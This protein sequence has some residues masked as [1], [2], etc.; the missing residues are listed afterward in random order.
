MLPKVSF[1]KTPVEV[2]EIT[3]NN[4]TENPSKEAERSIELERLIG[5]TKQMII[6]SL[7]KSQPPQPKEPEPVPEPNLTPQETVPEPE[8]AHKTPPRVP[9]PVTQAP[10]SDNITQ[11]IPT[12][13]KVKTEPD[14]P[15]QA[16]RIDDVVCLDSDEDSVKQNVIDL[17][18]DEASQASKIIP[19][20]ELFKCPSCLV[21]YKGSAGLKIHILSCF[22]NPKAPMP[23]AFCRV[24][25]NG[26]Q[27][28]IDHYVA[29]HQ[30]PS[31]SPIYACEQCG[32][33]SNCFR[34]IKKHVKYVHK[35]NG[36]TVHASIKNGQVVHNVCAIN[37]PK[38]KLAPKRKASTSASEPPQKLKRYGPQ[39]VDRLPINPILDELVHCSL[40]EF[41]TKVRVNMVRHLQLHAEQQPVPQTAPVNPVPHLET[42]EKHFDKMVNLASSSIVTRTPE[43]STR[44]DA[45]PVVSLHIPPEAASRF[46]K[47][48]PERQRHT[49]G[50]KGCSYISVD[51]AMLRCHW[52]TLHSGATDF[53][54]VHCPP[55][56]QVDTSRPLSAS[57]IITHLKMHDTSLYA[58]S[59]C[60][61]YHYNRQSIE[62]HLADVHKGGGKVM[63]VREEATASFPQSTPQPT[64]APTMDLKPWQCGLCKFKSML[65]PEVVEHCAKLH[66]SKMQ[67]K[68]VYC[69]FRTST[70]ENVVKHQNNTH[71]GK[72]KE[73]FYFYYRE[74][75]VPDEPDGTP[76]WQKQRQK[77]VT[78]PE[79]KT[80]AP[81]ESVAKPTTVPPPATT[82]TPPVN[83]DLNIVKKEVEDRSTSGVLTTEELCKKFGQF[84]EPNG[85]KYKCCLCIAVSEDSKE[86]MQ[87]HLFEELQYRKLV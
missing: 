21:T 73:I 11:D 69:P 15:S 47:Y 4:V 14:D 80:E 81:E 76:Y 51:E 33:E 85:L 74:G 75:S 58:C 52:E 1:N 61:F 64:T 54:C 39:D 2:E 37:N 65:R 53:H 8:A 38:P 32:K 60:S 59:N 71:P 3:P 17:S 41:N 24:M 22:D 78:E 6:E 12:L 18:D 70:L 56:Q 44:S 48:V 13:T 87:S 79:V 29:V 19:I 35:T 83:I 63:V 55:N 77:V 68:C 46:P 31:Q 49:C 42:N 5:T 28:L 23:C 7:N 72:E 10:P 20:N 62:K 67:Y 57:R 45:T 43:K 66:Q 36:C 9:T 16:R 86:A 40:C 84:C 25:T 27:D 50:A 30:A 82:P 26:R 34:T